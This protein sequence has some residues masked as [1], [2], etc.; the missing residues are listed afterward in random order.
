MHLFLQGQFGIGKS[1]LLRKMLEPA[2]S[3]IAGFVT[4]RL[5]KNGK[6]IG[7]RALNITGSLP[8]LEAVYTPG[9]KGIFILK[10]QT[11][12]PALE[13][14]ILQVEQDTINPGCKF[15]LLDEIGGVEL[16]SEAFMGSLLR[17]VSGDKPCI[18]VLKSAPN[19]AYAMSQLNLDNEYLRLHSRLEQIIR[20]KG[21]L[22]SVTYENIDEMREYLN[23]HVRQILKLGRCGY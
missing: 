3:S 9:Q 23:Q 5:M 1:S 22:I 10:G 2:S 12:I 15:I 21:E 18:G 6:K 4:Q 8:P 20:L 19:L 7:H 14:A 16:K 11:D 17:I 13:K